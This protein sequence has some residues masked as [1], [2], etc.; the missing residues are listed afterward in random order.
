MRKYIFIFTIILSI[1]LIFSACNYNKV[2]Q[3]TPVDFPNVENFE[4]ALN[5]GENL[6]GKTV[7]FP[8]NKITPNSSFGYNL[9][10]GEHLNFCSPTNPGVHIG[11]TIIVRVTEIYSVIGSYIIT[12]DLLFIEI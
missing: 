3:Q 10:A 2:E 4:T 5:N 1:I 11:D 7:S 8:V 9:M 12:Y 6:I